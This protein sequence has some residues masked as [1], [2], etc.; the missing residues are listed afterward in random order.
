MDSRFVPR[1]NEEM[2]KAIQD[3]KKRQNAMY[4]RLR[5]KLEKEQLQEELA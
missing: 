2:L 3:F 5:A 4:L 1:T